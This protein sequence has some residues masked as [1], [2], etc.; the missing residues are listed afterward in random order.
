MTEPTNAQTERILVVA[1][2]QTAPG[3]IGALTGAGRATT[4][5]GL[6][7]VGEGA[8]SSTTTILGREPDLTRICLKSAATAAVVCLPTVMLEARKRILQTLDTA[9]VRAATLTPILETLRA[10]VGAIAPSGLRESDLA[11]LVG[12]APRPVDDHALDA[13]LASKRVLITGAGGSIGSELARIAAARKPALLALMDR[14][15][16]ALFDI[17]REL[18]ARFPD[19]PRRV[20]LHDVVDEWGTRRLLSE[21][22][23][24]TVFHAAAH[25]H[26]PMMEDHPAHA[27]TNNVFG[28]R[29]VV[30]ASIACA[31]ERFVLISTDK[32]VNP[33]SVMGMTKRLAEIYV[34]SRRNSCATSLAT[35][36]FGN[37]L[38]SACSVLPIWAAQISEGGP[39]TVT[40]ARM[41]RYFMTIPEAAGLVAQAASLSER[42]TQP[43]DVYV[44]DMGQPVRILDLATRFITLHALTPRLDATPPNASEMPVIFTGARPGEKLNEELAYDAETLHPTSIPGILAWHGGPIT[45]DFGDAMIAELTPLRA[46]ADRARIMSVLRR[47]TPQGA[48]A[49]FCSGDERVRLAEAS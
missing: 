1:T 19:V 25:K 46:S 34:L 18:A 24:Q 10:G 15:E 26:V 27:V 16:N 42:D 48:D 20:L 37:V 29:A 23:P 7:L 9:G 3:A 45:G 5:I 39:V 38:G 32:A 2:A 8:C 36:R 11:A 17:D 14:S 31:A 33:T 30:D 40:D 13:A 22:R 49:L 41:T 4:P 47:W 28:A 6:V 12:R 21:V 35:V 43:A 44:L